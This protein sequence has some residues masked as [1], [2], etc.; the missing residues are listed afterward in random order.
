MKNARSNVIKDSHGQS[1]H[2]MTSNHDFVAIG[3]DDADYEISGSSNYIIKPEPRMDENTRQ[4]YLAGIRSE[5]Q[6]GRCSSDTSLT[7]KSSIPPISQE[8]RQDLKAG[9]RADVTIKKPKTVL[10]MR[11][12]EMMGNDKLAR[13]TS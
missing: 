10:E 9:K 11:W 5:I 2:R 8:E 6:I 13:T 7:M 3:S 12:S 4:Q 1:N